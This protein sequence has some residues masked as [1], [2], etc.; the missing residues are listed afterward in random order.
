MIVTA[1]AVT[2]L[3]SSSQ[4]SPPVAAL[5]VEWLCFLWGTLNPSSALN[6]C[7]RWHMPRE[8]PWR[9][10][11]ARIANMPRTWRQ[12]RNCS[13]TDRRIYL[14]SSAVLNVESGIGRGRPSPFIGNFTN[15]IETRLKIKV[16][17]GPWGAGAG[18][19]KP[20]SASRAKRWSES[21]AGL[22]PPRVRPGPRPSGLV[23]G[24]RAVAVS[25]N[26]RSGLRYRSAGSSSPPRA[27]G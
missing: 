15:P 20:D 21:P 7:S 10:S 6:A 5:S 8:S 14:S 26:C 22:R 4:F 11:P 1:T 24:G 19:V 18:I 27:P 2:P 13:A 12:G 9:E 23:R 16:K 3:Y 25:D 17:D